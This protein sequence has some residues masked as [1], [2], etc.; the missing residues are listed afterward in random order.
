MTSSAHTLIAIAVVLGTVALAAVVSL[1]NAEVRGMVQVV[2]RKLVVAACLMLP[3]EDQARYAEEWQAE[4]EEFSARPLGAMWFAVSV[5]LRARKTRAALTATDSSGA[6]ALSP[7]SAGDHEFL[8]FVLAADVPTVRGLFGERSDVEFA[9]DYMREHLPSRVAFVAVDAL[10]ADRRAEALDGILAV[11][12]RP[13]RTQLLPRATRVLVVIRNL[14]RCDVQTAQAIS[15]VLCARP[16]QPKGVYLVAGHEGSIRRRL[17]EAH[18]LLAGAGEHRHEAAVDAT[19]RLP[20][21][22]GRWSDELPLGDSADGLTSP[23]VGVVRRSR[24]RGGG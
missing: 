7:Q 5:S 22:A 15:T 6:R 11:L 9:L 3:R 2:A 10:L 19:W 24:S 23:S 21:G 12:D 16:L 18:D 13:A 4:L 14:D 1:V 8:A 17:T 20:R